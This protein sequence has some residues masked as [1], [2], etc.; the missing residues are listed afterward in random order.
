MDLVLSFPNACLVFV[1]SGAVFIS[2]L[3]NAERLHH[4][5]VPVDTSVYS[6]AVLRDYYFPRILVLIALEAS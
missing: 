2:K 6:T 5:L 3:P 1:E 4:S